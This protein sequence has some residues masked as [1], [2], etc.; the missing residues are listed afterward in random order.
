MGKEAVGHRAIEQGGNHAAV[1]DAGTSAGQ[2]FT[3]PERAPKTQRVI[4]RKK[5]LPG[6][7]S[8]RTWHSPLVTPPEVGMTNAAI[9]WVDPRQGNYMQTPIAVD[10]RLYGCTDYGLVTCFD[11]RTGHCVPT[12][13]PWSRFA[14]QPVQSAPKMNRHSISKLDRVLANVCRNCPL[15]CHARRR[16][17]GAALWLVHQH[18]Q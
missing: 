18:H 15:C 5:R 1:Q 4:S 13:L 16:Q 14:G 11:A 10:D 12:W 3:G 6:S 17:A 8:R 9:A 7:R 2:E